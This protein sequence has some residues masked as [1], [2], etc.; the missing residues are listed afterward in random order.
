[1]TQ[2]PP[3]SPDLFFETISAYQRT[4]ALVTAIELDLFT[5]IGDGARTVQ[6]IADRCGASVRGIRILADTLT[7]IGFLTKAGDAYTLTPDSAVFLTKHSPAY[8]GGTLAF[9]RSPALLGTYDDLT[10]TVRRGTV[11]PSANTVADENPI[12]VEFARAMMPMMAPAATAIA[13]ILDVGSM[14]PVRALDIAAGHGLFGI[15]LAQRNRAAEVVAVDWAPV[16][17][18]ATANADAMGVG[19]RHRTLA[20]DAFNVDYGTGYDLALLTNFLHHFDRATNVT[21]L[22]KVA[23]ALNTG[24]RIAILE[25]VPNDDRVSPAIAA[26][27]A[28]GMLAGTPAGDAYTRGEFEGMLTESGFGDVT[29]HPLPGPQ[30]VIVASRSATP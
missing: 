9:L 29:V 11:A 24:G 14:G 23:A 6:A 8:L 7:I 20:G 30:T 4:A 10:D 22:R 17:G 18:V 13:D 25:F 12:W 16:L 3:P 1:M 21:L 26:G 27:F 5:A 19:D 2:Q 15:A 28:L